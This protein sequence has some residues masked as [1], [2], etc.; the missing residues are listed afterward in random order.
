MSGDMGLY[1]SDTGDSLQ[2]VA[3][4]DFGHDKDGCKLEVVYA[5]AQ[6]GVIAQI[7]RDDTFRIHYFVGESMLDDDADRIARWFEMDGREAVRL[8]RERAP[9]VN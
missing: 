7:R 5:V 8:I 9:A 1:D 3:T 4:A 2:S 6:R